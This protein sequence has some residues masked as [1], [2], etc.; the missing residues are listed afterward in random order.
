MASGPHGNPEW[1]WSLFVL[2]VDEP[3]A[4]RCDP[5]PTTDPVMRYLTP[6]LFLTACAAPEK[7][8]A[9]AAVVDPGVER[10]PSIVF[11]TQ[12]W[13]T[14]GSEI[15]TT[16]TLE[17]PFDGDGIQ[18]QFLYFG[19]GEMQ[20]PAALNTSADE[21]GQGVQVAFESMPGASGEGRIDLVYT[22]RTQGEIVVGSMPVVHS[23]NLVRDIQFHPGDS[24]MDSYRSEAAFV[25]VVDL[26]PIEGTHAEALRQERRVQLNASLE[27]QAGFAPGVQVD[28]NVDPS[29]LSG[30]PIV[31]SGD[32]DQQVF[33]ITV[34]KR[35]TAPMRRPFVKIEATLGGDRE[36][37]YLPL[38]F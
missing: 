15:E 17:Q 14:V 10:M 18:L 13:E 20:L 8:A 16:L 24:M 4:S 38:R 3:E 29:R 32:S 12:A 25:V 37:E 35:S 21:L 31:R 27:A 28:S 19:P 26:E 2:H 7:E 22:S 33:L 6:L 1:G 5:W 36:V 34:D 9:P 11:S 23:R 30:L